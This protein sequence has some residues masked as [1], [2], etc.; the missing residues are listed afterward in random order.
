[1]AGQFLNRK[2]EYADYVKNLTSEL[3]E[4]NIKTVASDPPS[5]KVQLIL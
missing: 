4:C 3:T 1:L 2:K 5:L